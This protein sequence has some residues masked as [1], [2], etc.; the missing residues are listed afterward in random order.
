MLGYDSALWDSIAEDY[1]NRILGPFAREMVTAMSGEEP[2]NKLISDL[3]AWGFK[4]TPT[5]PLFDFGCGPGNLLEHL[6]GTF[7]DI[8]AA[9]GS[10]RALEIAHQRSTQLGLKIKTI[11]CDLRDFHP[12]QQFEV[13]VSVNSLLPPAPE[14]VPRLLKTIAQTLSPTGRLFAIIPSFEKVEMQID[15]IRTHMQ[16]IFDESYAELFVNEFKRHRKIDFEK[17]M[18]ADDLMHQQR[19]HTRQSMEDN[20]NAAGL[21]TIGNWNKIYYPWP[22]ARAHNYG[23]FPHQEELFDWYFIARRKETLDAEAVVG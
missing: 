17:L 15:Y 22:L 10:Q 12:S 1:D 14:D 11:L 8:V 3:R 6:V 9:D 7:I 20:L 18:Y 23:F 2:R 5:P 4:N 21:V 16:K 13:V 19:F